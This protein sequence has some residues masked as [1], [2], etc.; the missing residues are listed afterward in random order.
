MLAWA[1]I[2]A[3]ANEL[4]FLLHPCFGCNFADHQLWSLHRGG[5][6]PN[7]M[8]G[9]ARSGGWTGAGPPSSRMDP[10]GPPTEPCSSTFSI[11]T[12]SVH[13]VHDPTDDQAVEE[14]HRFRAALEEHLG[15]G[16]I[17]YDDLPYDHQDNIF[18]ASD[19]LFLAVPQILPQLLSWTGRAVPLSSLQWWLSVA[20]LSSKLN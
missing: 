4:D 13:L 1:L 10:L 15:E 3:E 9:I 6:V 18:L 11:F 2:N 12:Y 19:L 7:N 17:F 5:R 16:L 20:E 14:V 8:F